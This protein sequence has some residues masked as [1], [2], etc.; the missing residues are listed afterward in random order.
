[1]RYWVLLSGEPDNVL[2]LSSG[3]LLHYN[4]Q[5]AITLRTR[6]ILP[7]RHLGLSPLP[8]GTCMQ[9]Q[10]RGTRPLPSRAL[11]TGRHYLR[12]RALQRRQLR[13]QRRRTGVYL[14]PCRVRLQ[15]YHASRLCVPSRYVLRRWGDFLCDLP[16][17][18]L[19]RH[20]RNPAPAV[21]Q[22]HV[23]PGGGYQLYALSSRPFL[24][25]AV[26]PSSAMPNG[27]VQ[28]ARDQSHMFTVPQRHGVP[29][30]NHGSH[31]HAQGTVLAPRHWVP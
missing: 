31:N 16:R 3:P 29:Q 30:Q 20:C 21:P 28:P 1:V 13:Y 18:S 27:H 19:V 9:R 24:P 6:D 4:R 11:L 14:L 8:F 15:F 26:I 2:A 22:R 5:R 17:G 12:L 23:L 10:H 25:R 7:I